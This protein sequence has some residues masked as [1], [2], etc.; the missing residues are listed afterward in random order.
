MKTRV[1]IAGYGQTAVHLE[2]QGPVMA[3][4]SREVQAA[5]HLVDTLRQ[6]GHSVDYVTATAAATDFPETMAELKRYDVVLLG[7]ISADTLLLHPEGVFNCTMRPNRLK[8][9]R[10]FVSAGGGFLM[11]GGWFAFQ[12]IGG[13]GR[14]HL[15]PIEEIL[16]VSIYPFDDRVE[17]PEGEQPAVERADHPILAGVP[18]EWPHFLGHNRLS[19]KPGGETVMTIQGDPFLV[20]GRYGRGRTAAFA[21]SAAPHWAGTKEYTEWTGCARFWSNLVEWLGS[22]E[23]AGDR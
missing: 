16:P 7:D 14:Y 18:Q 20:V 12:G 15:T 5:R 13:S 2:I 3:S 21:S 23:R 8:L 17:S 11:T 1:L 22:E 4:F 9:I 10:E 19:P 6:A